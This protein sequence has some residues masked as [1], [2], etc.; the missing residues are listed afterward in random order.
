MEKEGRKENGRLTLRSSTRRREMNS[1]VSKQP[2]PL[3][4]TLPRVLLEIHA[5]SVVHHP[6]HRCHDHH[7]FPALLLFSVPR[8][9]FGSDPFHVRYSA[10]GT[11]SPASFHSPLAEFMK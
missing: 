7:P 1:D 4:C 8:D 6:H 9:S 3:L 11:T 2:I 5:R 10:F